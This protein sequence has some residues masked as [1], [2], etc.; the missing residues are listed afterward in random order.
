M[1]TLMAV[2]NWAIGNYQVL[3]GGMIMI[4]TGLITIFM[5]VPGEQPEKA[6]QSIVDFIKKFSVK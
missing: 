1:E 3:L 4:L 5:L 6:L 2:V